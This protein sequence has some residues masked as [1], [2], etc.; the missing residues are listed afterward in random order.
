MDNKAQKLQ[1]HR[2]RASRMAFVSS[3]LQAVLVALFAGS[4]ALPWS[5]AWTFGIASLGTTGAFTLAVAR[6]WNL[7]WH[8]AWLLHAQMLA[9]FA[10]QVVFIVAAPK[11]WFLFLA[12]TLV[13]F[14][15]AMVGFTPRQFR[16]TWAGFGAATA[17]ALWIGRD[18]FGYPELSGRTLA[19]VWLFFF[20]AMRRLGLIGMQFSTLREQLSERN[21]E[22]VASLARIQELASHDDLTGVFNRRHFMQLAADESGRA[23]RT[24]QPYSIALFDIDH[25]KAINDRHG[26]ATGDHV[27]RDFCEQVQ[28]HLR[29]TDRF[30]RYGGE[31]FVLLMPA[32]TTPAT[33]CT[34]VERI[35]L[36][37]EA[38]D[39]SRTSP[40][41]AGHQVTVS[42]GVGIARNGESVEALLVRTDAALYRAKDLGRNRVVLAE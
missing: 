4:G 41:L 24:G 34:A 37:I 5:T 17:L 33:A 22:L 2:L 7:R 29:A 15:Y 30:A 11:L 23:A 6:G 12:S 21:R 38:H 25:F 42:A 20:L 1:A 39:W 28:A 10:I 9:N 8:D 35:R 36:A 14:N 18:R 16:W 27:L 3:L 40:Q 19:L 32:T 26:H 31:E 13:S